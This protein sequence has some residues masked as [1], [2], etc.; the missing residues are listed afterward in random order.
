MK[1]TAAEV[2]AIVALAIG[3]FCV[4]VDF[5][6]LSLALPSMAV[7]LNKTTTD[8]QWVLSAYLIAIG[9][10]MIPAGRLGD[11]RGHRRIVVAGLVLFGGASMICGL[12]SSFALLIGFRSLQ[13]LGAAALLT[14]SIAAIRNAVADDRRAAAIGA[15]FGIASIGTAL[16]P[17]IGGLLTEQ[18]SWRWVFLL[19]VPLSAIAI[20]FCLRWV[21]KVPPAGASPRIDWVGLVLVSAGIVAF[22]YAADRGGEWG[23]GSPA[24]IGLLVVAVALLVA[25]TVVERRVRDPL[26]DMSLF[27]NQPFVLITIGGA[28]AN[29][30]Y[31]VTV[32][33]TTIYLQEGRGLSPIVSGLVF[34]APSVAVALSGPLAG[35]LA[36]WQSVP[37]LI[38]AALLFGGI[39]LLAVSLVNVWALYVPLLGLTGFALGLGWTLPNIGTQNVVE[40]ARAGAAA[41]VNLTIIVTVGGVAVAVAGTLIELGGAGPADI[42]EAA[43]GVMRML[44]GLSLV[45]GAVL[46]TIVLI[47]RRLRPTEVATPTRSA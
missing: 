41:G 32:L 24:L 7:D 35:R 44:S 15:L 46:L 36:E 11:L 18:A 29:I 17:F 38:P 10:A 22:A 9:A 2:R 26:I 39:C 1:F 13:G 33:C 5:F 28:I 43:Q 40:P 47:G 4:Q 12:S 27:R 45:G 34:L 8:L 37:L 21:S 42:D 31:A 14:V 20:I 23:W 6:A 25:F 3:L 16:G 30:V 19:N